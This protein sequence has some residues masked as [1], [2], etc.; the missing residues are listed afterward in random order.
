[1]IRVSDPVQLGLSCQCVV[2]C[3]VKFGSIQLCPESESGSTVP[4]PGRPAYRSPPVKVTQLGAKDPRERQE[5]HE[6]IRRVIKDVRW[7][8]W[9]TLRSHMF[10]AVPM[11]RAA[12]V[13][14]A[15]WGAV[16]CCAV[17]AR[18]EHREAG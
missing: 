15:S 8:L 9:W 16:L 17:C 1:M 10:G 4:P 6:A 13:D 7:G 11:T 18:A 14:S 5:W 2:F 3:G 12:G